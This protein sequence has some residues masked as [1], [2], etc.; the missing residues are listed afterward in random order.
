MRLISVRIVLLAFALPLSLPAVSFAACTVFRSDGTPS[1]VAHDPLAL[2]LA[3]VADCPRSVQ[4]LRADLKGKGLVAAPSMVANRGR[5][6]PRLGSF[7]FFEV[8]TGG[9][10]HDGEFFFGHFTEAHGGRLG[11][12]QTNGNGKLMIELIAW[13]ARKGF[14]NFYEMIGGPGAPRWFYRG[15]SGDILAD[16][17]AVNLPIENPQ[18]FGGRLRCSGCHASGGPIMKEIAAPHNDWWTKP[19]PLVFGPNQPDAEV[20]ETLARVRD[21]AG[22]AASVTTGIQHLEGSV[23]YQ[24]L[25]RSRSLAEQLRP[26][27]CENE[28]NI[29]SDPSFDGGGPLRIPSSFFTHPAFGEGVLAMPRSLYAAGTSS[30]RFPETGA[31]DADH[32]WL[33]PVR[34]VSDELALGSLLRQGVIDEKFALDVLSVD[35]E[36]PLFSTARCALLSLVPAAGGGAPIATWRETFANRLR[37]AAARSSDAVLAAAAVQ[38]LAF[39]SDPAW[40]PAAHRARELER[41]AKLAQSLATPAG[42][43]A[44]ID[45][46]M[47]TRAAVRASAISRNPR[48]QILE[49]GFRVIFPAP[50]GSAN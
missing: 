2:V 13:D 38:L 47:R 45:L 41:V 18:P 29:V 10:V 21:A 35:S 43:G 9:P 25:K 48:G 28:I 8:V 19:R 14:Y 39:L 24:N 7:S 42:A 1:A 12:D 6:N 31:P 27:F 30:L 22:F 33:T 34:S 3:S 5:N 26:L 32:A 15:D 16:T 20:T 23:P 40:T 44:A 49:P 50:G 46:L 11:L 37:S 36:H 4:E 17:R